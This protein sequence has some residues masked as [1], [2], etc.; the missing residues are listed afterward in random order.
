MGGTQ[1]WRWHNES[2]RFHELQM[3]ENNFGLNECSADNNRRWAVWRRECL[4]TQN[5]GIG[6]KRWSCSR[7]WILERDVVGREHKSSKT[8]V[9]P[10]L[11]E[12]QIH[13]F[14]P[15]M[16]FKEW[17][18]YREDSNI[19]KRRRYIEGLR[20]WVFVHQIEWRDQWRNV[21]APLSSTLS[22]RASDDIYTSTYN[23]H[24]SDVVNN[25]SFG[26]NDCNHIGDSAQDDSSHKQCHS[27]RRSRSRIK[28]DE[29]D[30]KMRQLRKLSSWRL[31]TVWIVCHWR[32]E[33]QSI[34]GEQEDDRTQIIVII[35]RYWRLGKNFED[36]VRIEF[37]FNCIIC[38]AGQFSTHVKMSKLWFSYFD[39]PIRE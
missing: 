22:V 13:E 27:R 4:T 33:S 24:S 3:I 15:V 7:R 16:K 10:D 31:Y 23:L 5:K 32:S 37:N 2:S 29:I 1:I 18:Q 6:E 17:G 39:F 30:F 35:S 11:P 36:S 34:E 12:I 20:K 14:R 19:E 9:D 26:A 8:I 28:N 21:T 38:E 25:D